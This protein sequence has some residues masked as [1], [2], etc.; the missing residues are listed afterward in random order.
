[1]SL[2]KALLSIALGISFHGAIIGM[3]DEISEQINLINRFT[4]DI[5]GYDGEDIK[6]LGHWLTQT[7]NDIHDDI[8]W[9]SLI[10]DLIGKITLNDNDHVWQSYSKP[11][12]SAVI[13]EI[14][15]SL[16][17]GQDCSRELAIRAKA[18][19]TKA[20]QECILAHDFKLKLVG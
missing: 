12:I 14:A 7:R 6:P 8:N 5:A 19:V 1:M 20:V 4:A 2:N 3:E 18:A 9:N 15:R 17:P 16:Q 10:N 13:S 11:A